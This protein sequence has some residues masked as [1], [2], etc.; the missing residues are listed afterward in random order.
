MDG[1]MDGWMDRWM[2]GW[3]EENDAERNSPSQVSSIGFRKCLVAVY[4][5]KFVVA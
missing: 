3:M 2:D 4:K 1:W 5:V